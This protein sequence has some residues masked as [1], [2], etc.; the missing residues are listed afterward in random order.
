MAAGSARSS[1]GAQP[2]SRSRTRRVPGRAN[3]SPILT[4]GAP[5]SFGPLVEDQ[6]DQVSTGVERAEVFEECGHSLA[7]EAPERLARVL[8][9]FMLDR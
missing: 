7:L 2:M 6:M 4:I 1:T 9:E 8:H 3:S 5:E